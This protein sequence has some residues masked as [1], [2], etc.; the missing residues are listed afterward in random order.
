MNKNVTRFHSN[1]RKY[2]YEKKETPLTNYVGNRVLVIRKINPNE[3]SSEINREISDFFDSPDKYFQN[4]S[5]VTVGKIINI[6]D[7]NDN[8]LRRKNKLKTQKNDGINLFNHLHGI[9][10]TLRNKTEINNILGKNNK[11]KSNFKSKFEVIDN[12]KLKM[13]F[14]F[15]KSNYNQ[16]L[17]DNS[18][19]KSQSLMSDKS[20]MRINYSNQRKKVYARN[21]TNF[22]YKELSQENV[23]DYIKTGLNLQT[24]KL[25]LLKLSELKNKKFAK[26]LSIKTNKPQNSL[27]LNRI[28]SFRFKKEVIKEMEYNKPK[29]EEFGRFKWNVNLRKPEHFRGVREAYVNLSEEKKAPFWSLIVEK[30]PKQKNICIKPDYTLNDGEIHSYQKQIKNLK[31]IMIN[32]D[33][34]PYFETIENLQGIMAKGKNLYNLEYKRE[35]ID[36]KS[37]KIWHKVF[38]E[39]GKTISLAE[40]NRIYGNETFYKNYDGCATEKNALSKFSKINF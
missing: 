27:L 38:V 11:N 29:G 12:E 8:R 24:R 36:S 1:K 40:V 7:I 31:T 34:N 9:A 39:N 3:K 4:N 16:S 13:I 22:T 37:K 28:D 6:F 5:P 15:Y 19:D 2:S 10:A 21:K 18:I 23:P 14:D 25:H 20:F 30:C 26:Y 35:I 32:D 33:K 17:K